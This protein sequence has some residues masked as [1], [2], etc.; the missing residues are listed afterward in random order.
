M[1]SETFKRWA[2]PWMA[3]FSF[4]TPPAY[5]GPWSAWTGSRTG[6]R[7]RT[8]PQA[9]TTVSRPPGPTA[10][11]VPRLMR[12]PLA[13]VS[14]GL[15]PALI[16]LAI[17]AL[18]SIWRASTPGYHQ[19]ERDHHLAMLSSNLA[20]TS[21]PFMFASI[22]ALAVAA[23]STRPLAMAGLGCS[24]L[25][26]SA[27]FANAMLSVALA[28]LNGIADHGGPSAPA[29]RPGS[30]PLIPLYLFP[31]YLAGAILAAIALWRSRAVPPWVALAIGAGGLLPLAIVT[32]I[33]AL[34]L[35]MSADGFLPLAIVTG[36]GT[37]ALPIAALRI[38]GGIPLA[39]ALLAGRA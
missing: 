29:S 5:P 1:D 16:A 3:A 27:I 13:V 21:F 39:R 26:L 11:A 30:P 25:G 35:P 8:D 34:A 4:F 6:Q 37:L 19:I 2:R 36:I 18:P 31:L 15:G 23:R 7:M 12:A 33:G 17:A 32:G 10:P 14:L 22:L 28:L 20:A 9:M 38:A 24:V